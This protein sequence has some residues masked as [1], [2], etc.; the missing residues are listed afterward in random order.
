MKIDAVDRAQTGKTEVVGETR[1][2]GHCAFDEPQAELLGQLANER[3]FRRLVVID[4][5]TET[6]PMVRVEDIRFGNAQLKNIAPVRELDE[7]RGGI[8]RLQFRLLGSRTAAGWLWSLHA[9]LTA[10][11]SRPRRSRVRPSQT[12]FDR[13]VFAPLVHSCLK[14]AYSSAHVG[15]SCTSL[16][17]SSGG[18]PLGSTRVR[19]MNIEGPHLHSDTICAVP[20]SARMSPA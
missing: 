5:P 19:R 17:A 12:S 6:P 9:A 18:R 7:G 15:S 2:S 13:S 8:S 20:R 16:T 3:C 1:E 10:A 4:R 14:C 11:A